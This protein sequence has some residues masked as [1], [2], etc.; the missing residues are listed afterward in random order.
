[1]YI[2]WFSV[3]CSLRRQLEADAREEALGYGLRAAAS[4]R[5]IRQTSSFCSAVGIPTSLLSSPCSNRRRA[6]LRD[7]P[8][9][10]SIFDPHSV[11]SPQP[12]A[13]SADGDAGNT[14]KPNVGFEDDEED[15]SPPSYDEA[16]SMD[17]EEDDQNVNRTPVA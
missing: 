9:V 2:H 8:P 11:V 7:P 15:P 1:M 13:A 16:I 3:M 10:Y 12:S 14:A 6:A 5:R 17:E 4:T